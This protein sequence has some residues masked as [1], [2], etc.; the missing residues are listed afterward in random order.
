MALPGIAHKNLTDPQLHEP[1]GASTATLNQIAFADGDGGT[2]WDFIT[3]DKLVVNKSTLSRPLDRSS[4]VSTLDA[5]GLPSQVGNILNVSTSFTDVNKNMRTIA[6]A[7]ND[8]VA[9]Y[10]LLRL[11]F[12]GLK[13]NYNTLLTILKSINLIE[14]A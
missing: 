4:A 3:P 12:Q 14:V 2:T 5:S 1:K 9:Q 13:N 11:D 6:D 7:Y 10:N 8:L